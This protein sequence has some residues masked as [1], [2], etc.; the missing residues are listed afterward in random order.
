MIEW[1]QPLVNI[2]LLGVLLFVNDLELKSKGKVA[3]SQPNKYR[4]EPNFFT[5]LS[6][7][8]L[9]LDLSG[10]NAQLCRGFAN[11]VDIYTIYNNAPK[12]GYNHLK[13]RC[14]IL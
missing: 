14:Y 4:P 13:F 2:F 11:K 8:P 9:T 1:F 7:P 3:L 12:L 6:P 5:Y 10:L